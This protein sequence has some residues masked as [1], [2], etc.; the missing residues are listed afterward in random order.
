MALELWMCRVG[1]GACLRRGSCG[2]VES[3]HR[4]GN[5]VP[6]TRLCQC[7]GDMSLATSM[8]PVYV[9]AHEAHADRGCERLIGRFVKQMRQCQQCFDQMLDGA[10]VWPDPP[11][12]PC[13]ASPEQSVEQ[14]AQATRPHVSATQDQAVQVG[15]S[16]VLESA[17]EDSVLPAPSVVSESWELVSDV[18]ATPSDVRGHSRPCGGSTGESS[19]SRRARAAGNVVLSGASPASASSSSV[20]SG[21][22]RDT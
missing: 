14:S 3:Q 1:A 16:D 2:M 19:G 22:I 15:S 20:P 9:E 4:R 11:S 10:F 17:V 6:S 12:S 21:L 13:R 8:T 5:R 7:C 18:A